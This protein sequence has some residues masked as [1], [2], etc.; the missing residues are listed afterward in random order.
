MELYG[1]IKNHSYPVSFPGLVKK[2]SPFL[3]DV[4]D[5]CVGQV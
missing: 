3:I 2:H 4:I 1:I 5:E